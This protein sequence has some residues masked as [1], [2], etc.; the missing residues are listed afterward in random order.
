MK[1]VEV[2]MPE[3]NLWKCA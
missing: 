2:K 3:I 1:M